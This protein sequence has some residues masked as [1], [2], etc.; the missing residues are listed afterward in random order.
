M[1]LSS[2]RATVGIADS[3]LLPD[4]AVDRTCSGLESR[5]AATD[6]PNAGP[7]GRGMTMPR[8]QVLQR[9]RERQSIDPFG[10]RSSRG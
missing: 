7:Y 6:A 5:I 3:I 8:L 9:T 4:F 2:L 10:A 1:F